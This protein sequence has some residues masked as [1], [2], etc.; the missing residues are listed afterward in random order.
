LPIR[1]KG[2]DRIFIKIIAL[3]G[4][5]W[6]SAKTGR[7]RGHRPYRWCFKWEMLVCANIANNE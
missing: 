3:F 5:Y 6:W 7:A 4:D 1:E 2:G